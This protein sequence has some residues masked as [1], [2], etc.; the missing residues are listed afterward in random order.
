MNRKELKE[1]GL[2]DEQVEAVMA[3]HGKATSE[4]K[5]RIG[6]LESSEANLKAQNQKHEKDLKDLQKDAGD[7]DA[8]KQTIKDL[9]K[10]NEDAKA[11]YEA[12]IKG[13]KRDTALE[14]ALSQSG[15]KNSKAIKAL[16]DADKILFEDNKLIGVDEQLTALKE[17]DPYMFDMG[18]KPDGYEPNAGGLAT[19]YSSMEEAIK[20]DDLDTYLAQSKESEE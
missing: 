20:A 12:E 14:K 2:T 13:I 8:L 6:Q 15:A 10:Q 16:L 5:E 4:F 19:L 18:K 11:D 9:Q 1:L 7:N 3:S 17:S